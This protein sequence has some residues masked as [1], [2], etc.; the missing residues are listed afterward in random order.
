MFYGSSWVSTC[1]PFNSESH[2]SHL[3]CQTQKLT[4]KAEPLASSPFYTH[5]CMGLSPKFDSTWNIQTELVGRCSAW[6]EA[7][8][9]TPTNPKEVWSSPKPWEY[10]LI[11]LKVMWL[12][13]SQSMSA[14]VTWVLWGVTHT[15]CTATY[16][17]TNQL[18]N[19][20]PSKNIQS[21]SHEPRISMGPLWDT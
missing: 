3:N 5:L 9:W 4:P 8:V 6:A 12:G 10:P 15:L 18:W 21:I 14:N 20:P 13:T 17:C 7:K 16:K 11:V 19:C 1:I 2:L